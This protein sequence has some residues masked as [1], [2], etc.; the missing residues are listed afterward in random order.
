M[1]AQLV[2]QL[3]PGVFTT[4]ALHP[5]ALG[6][7]Q[8]G[9]QILAQFAFGYGVD[10]VVD[11]LMPDGAQG[12]IGPHELERARDLRGRPVLGQKVLHDAKDRSVHRQF[13]AVPG[14][15]TVPAS[16]H[17]CTGIVAAVRRRHKRGG[18]ANR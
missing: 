15:E 12:V 6:S 11:G 14:F 2:G 16:T 8:A 10:G 7:A 5:F 13:G 18:P 9:D 3:P 1:Y 4:G 17:P